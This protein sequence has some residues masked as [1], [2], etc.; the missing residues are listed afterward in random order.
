MCFLGFPFSVVVTTC[1]IFHP[2]ATLTIKPFVWNLF[3]FYPDKPIQV[4]ITV[5]HMGTSNKSHVH[6]AA[7]SW[8]ESVINN[9]FTACVMATG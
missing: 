1:L 3:L 5:N 9:G 6:D 2:C 7:V 8:I 4:Q